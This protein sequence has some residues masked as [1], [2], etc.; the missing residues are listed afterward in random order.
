MSDLGKALLGSTAT[1]RAPFFEH[2]GAAGEMSRLMRA[3]PLR[4][5]S[6]A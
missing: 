3:R 2:P 6:I 1:Q 4:P 5:C